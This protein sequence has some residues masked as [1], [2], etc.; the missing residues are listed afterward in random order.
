MEAVHASQTTHTQLLSQD[1]YPANISKWTII[2][3]VKSWQNARQ[4]SDRSEGWVSS[5]AAGLPW[6]SALGRDGKMESL[7][8]CRYWQKT[9]T[10][11]KNHGKFAEDLEIGSKNNSKAGNLQGCQLS[12]ASHKCCTRYNSASWGS[13]NTNIKHAKRQHDCSPANVTLKQMAPERAKSYCFHGGT[14]ITL[15]NIPFLPFWE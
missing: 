5:A 12:K 4:W 1:N 11:T 2:N 10:K 13:E 14:F 3:R 9:K 8:S 7:P 15:T 6:P